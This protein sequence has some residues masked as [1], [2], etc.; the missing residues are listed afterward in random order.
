VIDIDQYRKRAAK[1][2][3]NDRDR[4]RR[5]LEKG[6][7]K[8]VKLNLPPDA[9]LPY[10]QRELEKWMWQRI[11]LGAIPC[12]YCRAAIDILSMEL[13][14]KVPLRRGGGPELDNK[15]IICRKCNGSKGDFTHDEYSRI[16][17][18]MEG[19]GAAFRQRLEGVLRNGGMATMMRFFP[20]QKKGDKQPKVTQDALFGELG[21]F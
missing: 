6:L 3:S 1:L 10:T 4:W 7:P 15:Q 2:Y 13:D 19:E 20:R 9:I 16:V 18:F 14:H 17:R 21:E 11:Q 5:Q 8:G 12:L